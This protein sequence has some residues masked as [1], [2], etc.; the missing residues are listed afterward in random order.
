M[1]TP[2]WHPG[3]SR[4]R[5]STRRPA[6]AAGALAGGPGRGGPLGV[7]PNNLRGQRR[8]PLAVPPA[9]TL[10]GVPVTGRGVALRG[11]ARLSARSPSRHAQSR[12]RPSAA[13]RRRGGYLYRARVDRG[14]DSGR[15]AKRAFVGTA[16]PRAP[17]SRPLLGLASRG[18]PNS[19]PNDCTSSISTRR[20]SANLTCH[21]TFTRRIRPPGGLLPNPVR[22]FSQG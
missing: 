1:P 11:V 16:P 8:A 14:V 6:R 20:P 17:C 10:G 12:L 2:D 5:S 19:L 9:A 21:L 3:P 18:L 13:M 7:R 4:W 22:R 15:A